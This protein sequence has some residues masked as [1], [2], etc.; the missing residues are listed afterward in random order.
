MSDR[1]TDLARMRI[2][3]TVLEA[4]KDAGDEIVIARKPM[5]RADPTKA[6]VGVSV[7]A[8][9]NGGGFGGLRRSA[10]SPE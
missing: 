9:K 3:W 6:M 1:K 4:A 2:I 5:L 7:M 10:F 8:A